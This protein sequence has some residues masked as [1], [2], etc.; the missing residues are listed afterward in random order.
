MTDGIVF[1]PIHRVVFGASGNRAIETILR[2]LQGA[3]CVRAG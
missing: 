3:V 2:T 1:E